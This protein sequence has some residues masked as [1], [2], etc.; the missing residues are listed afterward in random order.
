V[1]VCTRHRPEPLGRCLASLAALDGPTPEV[2]VVDNTDGD[3][4]TE[5]TAKE[6]GAR[7]VVEP[8][9][10]LSRARNKG[11]EEATGELV[12]FVDDD[13]IVEPAWL[14]E[15]SAV[16]VDDSLTA[17]SGRIL[18]FTL[19]NG[20][21]LLDLGDRGFVLDRSDPL[22]FERANF[23]GVAAGGS[24]MVLKRTVFESGLRFNESLG[25]GTDLGWF[26]EH[27]L[28][29]T[30]IRNGARVAYVPGAIVRHRNPEIFTEHQARR[31]AR[32][33]RYSGAYLMMLLVEE[34]EFRRRTVRY[35]V[36]GFTGEEL[37]WRERP[38][39]NRLK[40]LA[41]GAR[42]GLL[43]LRSRLARR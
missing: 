19:K 32:L 10:G 25:L 33:Y 9:I 18:P 38:S 4:N 15:H 36:R 6:A 26:E 16:L 13:A 17:S 40:M 37:P 14:E 24:N 20:R 28:F 12:A 34:P 29:F 3:P 22:W 23:G 30:I 11:I 42:G 27:Y 8:T 31:A 35:A 39:P 7:Y 5:R 43:Y 1:I 41:A 21:G 2:I